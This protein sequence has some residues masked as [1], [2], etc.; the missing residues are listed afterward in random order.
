MKFI[1]FVWVKF[2]KNGV[3]KI[4]NQSINIPKTTLLFINFLQFYIFL[5]FLTIKNL[6]VLKP[7]T[8]LPITFFSLLLVFLLFIRYKEKNFDRIKKR[9]EKLN[10]QIYFYLMII[11]IPILILLNFLK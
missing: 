6:V 7:H 9:V 11:S 10:Y 8:I 2:C 5:V 3:K 4:D 1:D